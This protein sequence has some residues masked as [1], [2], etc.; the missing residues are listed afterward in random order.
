MTIHGGSTLSGALTTT[1]RSWLP[2]GE[3]RNDLMLEVIR[4]LAQHRRC[5]QRDL[6]K[7][8]HYQ[9]TRHAPQ[10]SAKNAPR[11]CYFLTQLVCFK[12]DNLDSGNIPPVP[13][14]LSLQVQS[15]YISNNA[16]NKFICT[17]FSPNDIDSLPL[18]FVLLYCRDADTAQVIGRGSKTSMATDGT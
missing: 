9:L 13:P 10:I 3:L 6:P 16:L 7:V 4:V 17:A 12:R 11:R 15:R 14:F 8:V 2:W 5:F 1:L 18:T